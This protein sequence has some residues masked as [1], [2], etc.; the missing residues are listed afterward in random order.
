M[1]FEGLSS[2]LSGIFKKMR[3]QA[4]LTEKN[5][6]EMLSEVRK[7]LLEA[8]VNYDV[9]SDFIKEVREESIGQKVLSKVSPGDMVVKIVHDRMEK[10]LGDG[11]NDIPFRMDGKPTVI[12]MVGLQGTGKTTSAA[13]LAQLFET[14]NKKK[15][16]FGA[17]D[18]YR[19]A[20]IEQLTN[21]G[22]KCEPQVDT[23]SDKTGTPVPAI[24]KAAYEKAVAEKYNILILDTAGRLEIDDKLMKELQDIQSIIHVDETLLTV[25]ALVGQNATNVALTFNSKI[26]ITGL[27]MTK[28]D[29]DSRGGAALSIKKLTGI[30]IKYAGV[31]EKVSDFENFHPDRMADRILGMGDIVSLVEEMQEKIDASQAEK[32]SRRMQQGLFDLTDMLSLMKQMNRLGPLKKILMMLP[33][34]PKMDDEQVDA[35][36]AMLKKTEVIINSMTRQERKKPE[37]I[38]ASRKIRIAKGAGV[39]SN[40]VTKLVESF[41]TMKKQMANFQRNPMAARMMM[42]QFKKR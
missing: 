10:L 15:V 9:V 18:V 3:G 6:D 37:I 1:A 31:G 38:K 35:A 23:Y 21:L 14:K 4:T 8:D 13:K 7:A 11:D 26:K 33:N 5:M 42:S 27:I 20:A 12:M 32:T 39:Q 36:Q 17:L 22:L 28:L 34:M 24:A 30:P 41:D 25:D 16:L 2:R 40:D 29:G 19:P